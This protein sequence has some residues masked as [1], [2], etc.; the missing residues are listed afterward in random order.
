MSTAGKRAA[1]GLL[2]LLEISAVVILGV[3][4]IRQ[5]QIYTKV[6]KYAVRLPADVYYPQVKSD[7]FPNFYEPVAARIINDN[8]PWLGHN[9]S[10]SINADS[11][12]ERHDYPVANP[13]GGMR[14]ITLGD[15]FTYGLM[16][17]TYQNYSELL[18]DRLAQTCAGGEPYEVINLGVPAYDVGYGAERFRLRG[19]KYDPDLV[20][21]FINP[22]TFEIDADRKMALENEYLRKIPEADYWKEVN[23]K[24]E[25]YPGMLAWQQ[26]VTETTIEQNTQKQTQYF[27]EF[28]ALYPGPLIV[29]ANQWDIWDPV[30]TR[31]LEDALQNRENS[32][33]YRMDTLEPGT[34]LLADGHPNAEG[35]ARIATNLLSYL[36]NQGLLTCG[37]HAP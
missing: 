35:H 7:R 1:L 3:L 20:I 8:P 28:L 14:I 17:N 23:G 25:Y 31:M 5:L 9:V 34:D 4:V 26:L 36:T 32:R 22:F 2:A 29:I 37:Q 24:P 30:A 15:S 11:L 6:M 19:Q 18:E 21:W 10:Y 16:V 27:R 33:I 12:N 13:K